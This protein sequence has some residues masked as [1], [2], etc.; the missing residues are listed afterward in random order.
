M[1]PYG[2]NNRFVHD[3]YVVCGDATSFIWQDPANPNSYAPVSWNQWQTKRYRQDQ[4]E[5]PPR[6]STAHWDFRRRRR[7]AERELSG[8]L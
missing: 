8:A 4:E 7:Q 3:S 5:C 1:L 6:S 2:Q